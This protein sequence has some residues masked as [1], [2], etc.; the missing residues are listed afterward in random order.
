MPTATASRTGRHR[1][2]E[3]DVLCASAYRAADWS[4]GSGATI[5]AIG[6]AP[7]RPPPPGSSPSAG[8]TSCPSASSAASGSASRAADSAG[9]GCA[10][11]SVA[12]CSNARWASFAAY[13]MHSRSGFTGAAYRSV[14]R[15]GYPR[16]AEAMPMRNRSIHDE[17]GHGRL[18]QEWGRAF[19]VPGIVDSDRAHGTS[20]PV[21]IEAARLTT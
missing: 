10:A 8:N 21:P 16:A 19:Q 12:W 9:G 15:V 18:G 1:S 11:G 3:P 14:L 6:V 4:H 13:R 2:T 20:S 17:K 5:Y 7:S